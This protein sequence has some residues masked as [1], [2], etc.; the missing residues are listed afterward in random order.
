MAITF[1]IITIFVVILIAGSL[2]FINGNSNTI[3]LTP[4]ESNVFNAL[5]INVTNAFNALNNTI[6]TAN[7]T[8]SYAHWVNPQN[9]SLLYYYPNNNV[10]AGNYTRVYILGSFFTGQGWDITFMYDLYYFSWWIISLILSWIILLYILPTSAFAILNALFMGTPFVAIA[11][12][13]GIILGLIETVFIFYVIITILD[14]I[15]GT[16][17]LS[18]KPKGV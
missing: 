3:I 2:G 5:N 18:Q 12:I 14:Y 1:F 13:I 16:A 17:S 11:W 15:R 7:N 6:S 4:Q 10:W 9:G 8:N